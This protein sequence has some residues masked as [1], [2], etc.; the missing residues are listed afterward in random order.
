MAQ[1]TN[2]ELF[3]NILLVDLYHQDHFLASQ[4][5]AQEK[6]VPFEKRL[7]EQ[8]TNNSNNSNNSNFENDVSLLDKPQKFNYAAD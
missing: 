1:H 2:Y 6:I 7:S 3:N 8:I 5:F 4:A